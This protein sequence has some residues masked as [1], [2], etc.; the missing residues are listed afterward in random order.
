MPDLARF[1][2]IAQNASPDAL[3]TELQDMVQAQVGAIIF[4]CSTFDLAAGLARRAYT[5]MPD[6]YPLSGLKDITPNR[7]TEVVL[8]RG[9]TFVANTI[10]EIRD[11]FPDHELIASLG[12]GSVINMPVYVSGQFLGTVNVLESAGHYT[13]TRVARMQS[14][15]PAAMLAFA[16]F[17]LWQ[18]A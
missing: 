8:D 17:A 13:A 6:V 10:E 9:E 1:F 14:L 2:D 15:A 16:S 4:S 5:N 18:Q 11:V 12:C 3:F 7:W